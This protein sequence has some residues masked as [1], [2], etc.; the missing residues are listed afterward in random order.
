MKILGILLIIAGIAL[1]FYLGVWVMFIGGIVTLVGQIPELSNG[2][3]DGITIGLG[4]LRMM[5][6]TVVG[7]IGGVIPIVIGF[8]L[9][10]VETKKKIN[11]KF[12]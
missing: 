2:N 4:I 12:K 5:F 11:N 8:G 7:I 1:G 9:L 3:V 10:G 6:A